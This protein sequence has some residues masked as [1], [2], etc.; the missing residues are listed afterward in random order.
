[1]VPKRWGTNSASYNCP[2][3]QSRACRSW[4]RGAEPRGSLAGIPGSGGDGAETQKPSKLE[5]IGQCAE[6]EIVAQG[7][8]SRNRQRASLCIKLRT[9][10]KEEKNLPKCLRGKVPIILTRAQNSIY[11][12]QTGRSYDSLDIE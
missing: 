12:F 4:C 11:L 7:E 8:N 2:S 1:M 10:W 5:V 6:E 9:W 3:L